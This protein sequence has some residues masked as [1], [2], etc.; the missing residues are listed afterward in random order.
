M[1]H[2]VEVVLCKKILKREYLSVN[3]VQEEPPADFE[4]S[5]RKYI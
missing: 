4:L 1:D 2:V 5:V 3:C